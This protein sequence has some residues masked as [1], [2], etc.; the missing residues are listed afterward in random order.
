MVRALA[1]VVV[2]LVLA[3]GVAYAAAAL[4]VPEPGEVTKPL[5]VAPDAT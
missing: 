1:A 2:G 3:L 4:V 5:D